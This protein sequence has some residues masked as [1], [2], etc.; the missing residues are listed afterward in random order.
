MFEVPKKADSKAVPLWTQLKSKF[1]RKNREVVLIQAMTRG[2]IARRDYKVIKRS[3]NDIRSLAIYIIF[4]VLLFIN[5]DYRNPPYGAAFFATN[6]LE[7]LVVYEEFPDP[8]GMHLHD[9]VNVDEYWQYVD[10]VLVPA[11]FSDDNIGRINNVNI[12]YGPIILRQIRT[13]P[14][15]SACFVP[16]S[17]LS[18]EIESLGCYSPSDIWESDGSVTSSY[19]PAVNV[20]T[21]GDHMA[22]FQHTKRT[23][24]SGIFETLFNYWRGPITQNMYR[25]ANE[26]F[27]CNLNTTQDPR[28]KLA[29][30]KENNWIDSSTRSVFIEFTLYNAAYKCFTVARIMF[31][32]SPHGGVHASITLAR[33]F[34]GLSQLGSLFYQY[35]VVIILQLVM[36][37]YYL[38]IEIREMCTNGISKYLRNPWNYLEIIN[39]SMLLLS[40]SILIMFE[41]VGH[42]RLADNL[43]LYFLST[44]MGIADSI[45]R[46]VSYWPL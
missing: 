2:M 7:E 15:S 5:L 44:V 24:A 23:D 12:F 6:F 20:N 46:L 34:F 19:G 3:K 16:A 17:S 27:I 31:E 21:T 35:C 18:N 8:G 9:V 33:E 4:W 32:F 14:S 37:T 43:P 11:L 29:F 25:L 28:Q 36:L 42:Q 13:K 39:Y 1:S 40:L 30:L 26:G 10:D 38:A 41:Y 22:C 45:T